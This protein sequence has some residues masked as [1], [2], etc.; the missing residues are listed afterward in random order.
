LKGSKQSEGSGVED[1]DRGD[2]GAAED[3]VDIVKND[4][5]QLVV[6]GYDALL[7]WWDFNFM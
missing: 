2:P 7:V 6:T 4:V 3:V 5:S 1:E